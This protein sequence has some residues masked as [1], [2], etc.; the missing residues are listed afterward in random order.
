M[1]QQMQQQQQQQHKEQQQQEQ[2]KQQQQQQ[3]QQMQQMQKQQL[4]TSKPLHAL[5]GLSPGLPY[6]QSTMGVNGDG[7]TTTNNNNN[8]D[9]SMGSRT[10][11][12]HA[13]DMMDGS[14]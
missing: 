8:M 9:A 7:T 3:E 4:S 13:M 10:S 2:Q 11:S 6:Y 12:N 1:Q 14:G 5:N